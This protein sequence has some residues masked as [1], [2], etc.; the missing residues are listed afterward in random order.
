VF[1][2]DVVGLGK[3]YVSALLARE[4]GGKK[5]VVCPPVLKEYWEETFMDFGVRS[6]T[7]VSHGKLDHIINKGNYYYSSVSS[8]CMEPLVDYDV[9]Q[10]LFVSLSLMIWFDLVSIKPCNLIL[11]MRIVHAILISVTLLAGL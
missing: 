4:L 3:T 6:A 1:L 5:L 9:N 11:Q 2:S 10:I 7:V 8:L